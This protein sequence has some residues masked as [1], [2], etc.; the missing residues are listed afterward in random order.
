[1]AGGA[2]RQQGSLNNHQRAHARSVGALGLPGGIRGRHVPGPRA[3][4][5]EGTE[6]D[7]K[8]NTRR[9][10]ANHVVGFVS[11]TFGLFVQLRHTD[12]YKK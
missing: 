9:H 11:A 1:M 2:H 8:G 4:L 6:A 10:E 5:A 7:P 12:L 3:D